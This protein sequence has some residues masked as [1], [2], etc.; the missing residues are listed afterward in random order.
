M[1]FLIF[2]KNFLQLYYV[3][4]NIENLKLKIKIIKY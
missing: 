3:S 1:N 4:L 2:S